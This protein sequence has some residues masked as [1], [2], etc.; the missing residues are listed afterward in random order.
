MKKAMSNTFY[1]SLDWIGATVLGYIFWIVASKMLLTAEVGIFSTLLNLALFTITFSMLGMNLS[2]QKLIPEYQARGEQE[3]TAGTVR[4]TLKT[5][6]LINLPIAALLVAFSSQLGTLGYLSAAEWQGLGIMV[7]GMMFLYMSQA[8]LI[9]LQYMRK[10]FETNLVFNVMRIAVAAALIAMAAS[11]FGPVIAFAASA[12]VVSAWRLKMVPTGAGTADKKEV[13]HYALPFLASNFGYVMLNQGSVIAISMMDTMAAVGLFTIAFV[14]TTPLKMVPQIISTAIFPITSEQHA[15]RDGE[16]IRTLVTGS[17]R[18]SYMLVIPMV[19]VLVLFSDGFIRL[20]AS[21]EY[22][23]ASGLVPV[24]S[25]GYVLAGLTMIFS[26]VLYTT[27][28]V[29]SCRNIIILGGLINV[30]GAFML[31]PSIGIMG[32]ALAFM[33]SGLVTF[34]LGF[35]WLHK[36]I[37]FSAAIGPLVKIAVAS[38]IAFSVGYAASTLVAGGITKLIIGGAVGLALYVLML[39]VVKLFNDMD[40]KVIKELKAKMPSKIR[41]LIEAAERMVRRSTE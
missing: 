7:V 36:Y 2:A 34:V 16:G 40:L 21:S 12:V 5:A 25:V 35:L 39:P 31:I 29:K 13:W 20:F 28:N 33:A 19:T 18:Y 10:L 9:G 41:P 26:N 37:R 3:K 11:F 27:G 30:A 17:L 22:A 24:L 1:L 38:A 4:W 8:Y 32:A 23:A 6:L 14:F 15:K